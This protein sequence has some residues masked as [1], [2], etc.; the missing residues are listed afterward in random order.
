MPTFSQKV[1]AKCRAA[2]PATVRL[3]VAAAAWAAVV[4]WAKVVRS[5]NS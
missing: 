2:Q 5:D 1:E 3:S 4:Q